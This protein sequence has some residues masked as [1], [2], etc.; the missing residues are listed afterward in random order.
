[1]LTPIRPARWWFTCRTRPLF[2]GPVSPAQSPGPAKTH[3][4]PRAPLPA[5]GVTSC[6]VASRTT[7]AGITP[8]SSLL[9]AH[10]P[11]QNPPPAYGHSLGRW[12]FAGCRQSLLG[13]GPSRHYLRNPCIGAWSLTPQRPSGALA[14]FF[15]EDSGLAPGGTSSARTNDRRNATSTTDPISGLQTFVYLQAPILARP[16]GCTHRCELPSCSG[17]GD[18]VRGLNVPP[19]VPLGKTTH[20]AAGPFTPRIARLVTC[21]EMWHRY[22]SDTSN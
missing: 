5:R 17:H 15:P 14:R 6:G 21:P 22:V 7:S 4:V 16:P 8:L 12:V 13:V 3:Q 1:M 18:T 10:A 9:L 19:V 20:R 2:N 11:D